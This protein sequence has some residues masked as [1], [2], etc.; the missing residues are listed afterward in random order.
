MSMQTLHPDAC[1]RYAAKRA[2]AGVPFGYGGVTLEG[3]AVVSFGH[4]KRIKCTFG[5][6]DTSGRLESA[7]RNDLGTAHQ[8]VPRGHR[9]SVMEQRSISYHDRLTGWATHH[10]VEVPLGTTSQQVGYRSVV[11]DHEHRI[12]VVPTGMRRGRGF[13]DRLGSAAA[14]PLENEQQQYEATDKR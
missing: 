13:R 5:R 10:Y 8:P 6:T 3:V 2:G 11:V 12:R 4:K 7:D 14:K 9:R 1:S